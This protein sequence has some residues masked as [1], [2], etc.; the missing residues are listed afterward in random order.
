MA[1]SQILQEIDLEI[2]RLKEVRDL[3]NRDTTPTKVMPVSGPGKKK[4]KRSLSPGGRK[5]IAGAGQGL[6]FS[7][8]KWRSFWVLGQK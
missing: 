2:A 5:R 8:S 1:T 4:K 3:L 7:T 6:K